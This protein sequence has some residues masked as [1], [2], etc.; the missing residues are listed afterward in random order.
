MDDASLEGGHGKDGRSGG[1]WKTASFA[2]A[3]AYYA[4]HPADAGVDEFRAAAAQR[5][6][7][8]AD[9]AGGYD[10]RSTKDHAASGVQDAS[11]VKARILAGM[12]ERRTVGWA[13]TCSCGADAQP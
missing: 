11:A 2:E 9:A 8:G 1:R 12:V 3:E 4:E 13:P 7:C 6:A 10:G 5:A